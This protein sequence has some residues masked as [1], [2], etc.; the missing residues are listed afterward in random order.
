MKILLAPA[1]Y[2]LDE[3]RGGEYGWAYNIV[4]FLSN[5]KVI[6]YII[7]GA[8]N[9]SLLDE[10]SNCIFFP[11][12]KRGVLLSP[13]RRFIFTLEYFLVAR[14]I[15]KKNHVDFIHHIL[16][17]GFNQTF[18][19]LSIL[20][21][22]NKP[23]IIGPVQAPQE[24]IEK[25][26]RV[27]IEDNRGRKVVSMSIF[28]VNVEKIL[29]F[30]SAPIFKI[31]FNYTVKRADK[32]IAIS[33]KA[34]DMLTS[35]VP[36]SKIKIIPPGV[37][38]KLWNFYPF[39]S[40]KS[41][42]INIVVAGYFV[43]R[44]AIDLVIKAMHELVFFYKISD[45]Q[46]FILGDG[47]E[48]DKL[49]NLV[50]SLKLENKINFE[51]FVNNTDVSSYYRTAHIFVNMSYSESW[52]QVYLEA[53]ACGLPIVTTENDGSVEIIEDGKHG[54]LIP[55]GNYK[56]LAEKLKY[57]CGRR[58]LLSEMGRKARLEVEYKYDWET[59]IMPKYIELYKSLLSN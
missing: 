40:K 5:N 51:G 45:V 53:M 39:E 10:K 13:I 54:Y 48:K 38:L 16:P 9:S 56:I 23:F 26:K 12:F 17:F 15:I 59:V 41:E 30:F 7:C 21:Y 49:L 22:G 36:E 20:R 29:Y 28:R 3:I 47:P 1:H 50:Q 11:L 44:K 43:K 18:N 4:K 27:Y 8:N 52:G 14:K 6:L 35:L 2:L 19:L 37:D 42:V 25:D 34:K 24:Y 55:K 46:L 31:L 32:I 33:K 58:D 57:L